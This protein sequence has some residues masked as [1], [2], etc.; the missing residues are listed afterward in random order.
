MKWFKREQDCGSRRAK[1]TA[2]Q[3]RHY[4]WPEDI[5]VGERVKLAIENLVSRSVNAILIGYEGV[6]TN[7]RQDLGACLTVMKES[8]DS[9][10][11][12]TAAMIEAKYQAP[13]GS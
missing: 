11:Q 2:Y 9:K 5:W 1:E 6:S 4:T 12:E 10:V 8:T 3:Y 7:I 13:A